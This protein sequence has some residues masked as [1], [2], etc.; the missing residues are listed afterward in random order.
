[1]GKNNALLL[2]TTVS[3]EEYEEDNIF[4]FIA[5]ESSGKETKWQHIITKQNW[6]LLANPELRPLAAPQSRQR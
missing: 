3:R 6:N 5:E 2:Y 1:M 4:I